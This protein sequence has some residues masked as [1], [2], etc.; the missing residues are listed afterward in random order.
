MKPINIIVPSLTF[1]SF[2]YVAKVTKQLLLSLTNNNVNPNDI[3]IST[4]YQWGKL[5]LLIDD[6]YVSINLP[7]FADIAW[8]DTALKIERLNSYRQCKIYVCS[9]KDK[10]EL[11][12][13]GIKVE[14]IVPRPFN[15]IAYAYRSM[16]LDKK[17]DVFI[18]GWH[19]EPDRKNFDAAY[20][21]VEKL[22]LNHIAVTN[23]P[24]FKNRIDFASLS[25]IEKYRLIAQ[26]KY[27]LH[28][29]GIE[30]FGLPPLEGMSI[31]VPAIYL[32]A[33]A[34]NEFAI[35]FKVPATDKVE[36]R[37]GLTF[38]TPTMIYYKPNMAE[39]IEIVKQALDVYHT[40][41]YDELSFKAMEKADEMMRKT[42]NFLKTLLT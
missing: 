11:E 40:D 22:N 1:N 20:Q 21:I 32:D 26:S 25:D 37:I 17:Y 42:L 19:R 5:N 33:P 3:S 29:A 30:G 8:I 36:T 38:M 34:V 41:E 24:K 35:G 31:G 13:A 18:C 10:N 23:Y 39:A 15:P 9:N 27:I 4:I 6:A 28:L 2:S 14:D 16:S 7:K 12:N